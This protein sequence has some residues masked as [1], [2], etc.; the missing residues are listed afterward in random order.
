[1][2]ISE[3]FW[4]GM[5]PWAHEF[6]A[7]HGTALRRHV[8]IEQI[9]NA[10]RRG[11]HGYKHLDMERVRAKAHAEL[12]EHGILPEIAKLIPSDDL[13]AKIQIQKAATPV[14]CR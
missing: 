14:L 11:R 9:E 7:R 5:D 3:W 10:Y 8:V 13:L 12:P 2:C 1:M 4:H 6:L